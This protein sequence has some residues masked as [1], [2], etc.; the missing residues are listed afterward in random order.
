MMISSASFSYIVHNSSYEI[1]VLFTVPMNTS[2][3]S[4]VT[5]KH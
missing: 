5:H 1:V 4:G 3:P 2:A